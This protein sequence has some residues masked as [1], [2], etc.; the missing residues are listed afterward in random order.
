MAATPSVSRQLVLAVAVPLVL[1]FALTILALD[2]IF[3]DSALQALRERLDQEVIALVTAAE[4]SDQGR[5]ELRLLDPDSRLSRPRSGQ[6]AAVRTARGRVLWSSPSIAGLPIAFG[7]PVAIGHSAF[8]RARLADGTEVGILNRGLAWDYAPGN[9]AQLVFSVAED[10]AGQNARLRRFHQ[11]LIAWF[12]A[13][14]LLL[15][16]V[17]G[18]LLRRVLRPVRRLEQEIAEVDSGRRAQLGDGFPRELAGVAR[19]LNVLLRSEQRRI[20]RYRDTLGNLAHSLKT[21]LA[22][23]RASLSAGADARGGDQRA[24]DLR[25]AL[26]GEIDRIARIVDHQLQRAATSGG[27]SLGQATLPVAPV[28]ADLRAAMRKVHALKDLAIETEVAAGAGFVGDPGDLTELLGNL[29]DNAC[30]WCRGRV[31]V[32]VRLEPGRPPAQAL[33]IRVEDDGPGIAPEDRSRVQERG[34]RAD[35][36]APGHGLGLAMVA[37]TVA[38]YGGQ[39]TIGVSAALR[40]ACLEVALPGRALEADVL[41]SSG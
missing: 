11:Q 23:M 19:S 38:L 15:L 40:G 14:A 7:A 4:L 9:S 28:L 1:S 16:A 13:L 37:D 21:P 29:I 25:A 24:A 5:M 20:A 39:L 31:R 32:Q 22:V 10:L 30:K 26:N 8:S 33:V 3:H 27:A 12:A 6:Y 36:R 34:V 17:L 2:R 41:T 35:E 18:A